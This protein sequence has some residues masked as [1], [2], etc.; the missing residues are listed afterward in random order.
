[1]LA[2]WL[3]KSEKWTRFNFFS[4]Y[5]KFN[6]FEFDTPIDRSRRDKTFGLICSSRKMTGSGSK[7]RLKIWP[8]TGNP[9]FRDPILTFRPPINSSRRDLSFGTKKSKIGQRKPRFLKMVEIESGL[10]TRFSKYGEKIFF[11]IFASFRLF[12]A[13]WPVDS[14]GSGFRTWN[15]L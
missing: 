2:H 11:L 10:Q 12:G 1:M 14:R 5:E 7:S 13:V 3:S 8:K 4:K 9:G 6:N 15:C